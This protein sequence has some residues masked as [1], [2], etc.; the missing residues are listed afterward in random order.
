[1]YVLSSAGAHE[2]SAGVQN[3]AVR[4]FTAYVPQQPPIKVNSMI[5]HVFQLSYTK[6]PEYFAGQIGFQLNSYTTVPITVPGH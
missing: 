4:F 3:A 5:L 2:W 6:I 1:M